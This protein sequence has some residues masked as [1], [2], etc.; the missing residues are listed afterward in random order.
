MKFTPPRGFWQWL[1]CFSPA[2]INWLAICQGPRIQ[3]A[4]FGNH[5]DE[6]AQW[7]WAGWGIN[8]LI[9]GAVVCF[10]LGGWL[11]RGSSSFR[12]KTKGAVAYG[13]ALMVINASIAFAGCAVGFKG[14]VKL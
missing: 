4:L 8:S 3:F 6:G 1:A 12:E 13:F 11:V 10:G 2:I 7:A 9:V 5:H 14:G